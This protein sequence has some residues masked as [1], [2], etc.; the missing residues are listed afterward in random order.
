[1]YYMYGVWEVYYT[2]DTIIYPIPHSYTYTLV[3]G[4]FDV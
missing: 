2:C 4:M 3:G 1:M